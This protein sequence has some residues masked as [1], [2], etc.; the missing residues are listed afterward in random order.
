[1]E[2]SRNIIEKVCTAHD[3]TNYFQKIRSSGEKYMR[4]A[5]LT[6]LHTG[7][8][9]EAEKPYDIIKISVSSSFFFPYRRTF[10]SSHPIILNSVG[11]CH[12]TRKKES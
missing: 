4:D 10:F 12:E 3:Q 8:N 6:S 5:F 11:L 9:R 7:W 1:M 2:H